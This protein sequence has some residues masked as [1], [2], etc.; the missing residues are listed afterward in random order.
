MRRLLVHWAL[1][2]SACKAPDDEGPGAVSTESDADP[3]VD[4]IVVECDGGVDVIDVSVAELASNVLA[5]NVDVQLAESSLAEV[6]CEL[7]DGPE[8]WLQ[9]IPL[10]ATWRFLDT[11]V[12]PG[13]GWEL[14]GFD[15]AGW[16]VGAAMFGF[17]DDART[18][19]PNVTED[20]PP[21]VTW[22][23]TDFVLDRAADVSILGI[24]V[25]RDDGVIVYVNGVEA[26]RDN[27]PDGPVG[28]E[29]EAVEKIQGSDEELLLR[30]PSDA[31]L[32]VDGVNTVAVSVHQD[33]GS[34][35]D[36]TFELRMIARAEVPLVPETLT[37]RGTELG[38]STTV[39]L[40]G[41]LHDA[42]YACEAR[43]ACGG[44]TVPFDVVTEELDDWFP[45]LTPHPDNGAPSY[46]AWTLFNHQR[47]CLGDYDNRLLV[48][49]PEG[50]VRWYYL[51]PQ[52]Q[53][54]STIDIE[55]VWLG[56]GTILWGGADDPSGKPQIVG[57]DH[58]VRHKAAWP[59]VDEDQYHHDVAMVDGDIV[60]LLDVDNFDG[61][62]EWEGF[63][64][65]RYDPDTQEVVWRWDSQD[66]YDRGDFPVDPDSKDPEDPWHANAFAWTEDVDGEGVYVSLLI[67]EAVIRVDVDDGDITWWAGKDQDFVLLDENGA[68]LSEE[69]WFQGQHGVHVTDGVLTAYDNGKN[70]SHAVAVRLD[71]GA[72]TAE[73]V[74]HWTEFGWYEPIWGDADLLPGGSMLIDIAHAECHGANAFHPGGLVDVLADDTV[75][76]RLDMLDGEDASYR[77]QR[78]EGCELFGNSRWC[79]A[80]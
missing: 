28:P 23:R 53:S 44:A 15:D 29:T 80:P 74:K 46:G 58:V 41:M 10:G 73:L 69:L 79:A 54:D 14:P 61:D 21:L 39:H 49:D 52:V 67:E 70:P 34:S 25:V 66:A 5:R 31:G 26:L 78:I 32:L 62:T 76:W 16:A 38:A 71:P 60:G 55:S 37:A 36:T 8:R 43:S 77:A 35:S 45:R 9:L 59:G 47:P 2:S 75:P 64:I 1:V 42:T 48:V 65:L 40:A 4:T 51:I 56:D 72:G 22:Y 68:E 3:A 63:A 19:L 33:S 27:L 12:F 7:V 50:Q 18:V 24:Q 30:F 11:G 20:D 6:T 13:A 17:G 57:I